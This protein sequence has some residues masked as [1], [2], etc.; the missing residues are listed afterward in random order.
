MNSNP[1]QAPNRL[2]TLKSTAV[3][4]AASRKSSATPLYW[5]LGIATLTLLLA[6]IDALQEGV[7]GS[8][9]IL[10]VT[11]GAALAQLPGLA[12]GERHRRSST[13]N[14]S[15]LL[16][17]AFPIAVVSFAIYVMYVLAG[18]VQT[19]DNAA[20]MHVIIIPVLLVI[21]AFVAYA[22]AGTVVG[23]SILA[24]WNAGQEK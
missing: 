7:P 10:Q 18:Q 4:T 15:I 9:F 24:Q 17:A 22:F 21:L 3:G 19:V 8:V 13:R 5:L 23:I 11:F 12:I 6:W 2:S 20:Q 14:T 1:Y 16:A